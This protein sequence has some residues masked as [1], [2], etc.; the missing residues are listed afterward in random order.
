MIQMTKQELMDEILARI[1][2][3]QNIQGCRDEINTANAQLEALGA[4]EPIVRF[5]KFGIGCV[6]AWVGFFAGG[7]VLSIIDK[8]IPM[9]LFGLVLACVP[10][11][12]GYVK[13]HKKVGE[14]FNKADNEKRE[15]LQKHIENYEQELQRL[16]EQHGEWIL[17]VLPENYAYFNCAEKIYGY[18]KNGRADSLKEAL[19]LYESELNQMQVQ[20]LQQ[21]VEQLQTEVAYATQKAADAESAI[22]SARFWG[23][24]L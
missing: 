6:G 1:P 4:E 5:L 12:Y 10:A 15:K 16:I 14:F 3:L 24:R 9:G 13:V 17:E 2:V 22:D 23:H 19:N 21:Q 11:I 7:L 8:I 20:Q 18:L